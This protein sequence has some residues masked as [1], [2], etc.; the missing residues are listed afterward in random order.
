MPNSESR[1]HQ[2]SDRKKNSEE[3]RKELK[4]KIQASVRLKLT[5][6][7]TTEDP[8]ERGGMGGKTYKK[9]YGK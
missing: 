2:I 6:A 1:Q 4:T 8:N 5:A 7:I 9:N 3:S